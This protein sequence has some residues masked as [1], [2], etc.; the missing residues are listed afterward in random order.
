MNNGKI[1]VKK[2][3]GVGWMSPGRFEIAVLSIF[4]LPIT[5]FCVESKSLIFSLGGIL[6]SSIMLIVLWSVCIIPSVENARTIF[7][8]DNDEQPN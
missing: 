4:G 3:K 7:K 8:G 1:M 2:I 6:F 5:W